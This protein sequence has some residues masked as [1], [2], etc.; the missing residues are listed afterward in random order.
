VILEYEIPKYD[1]DL[2][3][4]SVFVH[5]TVAQAD[6]KVAAL[7]EGFPSQRGHDWFS[8]D[9]FRGLMRLRGVESRAP[10]GLA[11]A[12]HCAKLVLA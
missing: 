11:E 3:R 4:P 7:V 2:G 10:D 8:E 6:A 9:T 5:L 1:G 12:F